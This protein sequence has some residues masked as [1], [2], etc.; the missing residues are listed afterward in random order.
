MTN[1]SQTLDAKLEAALEY[2]RLGWPVFPCRG[3]E[4]AT[5]HGCRD[6]TTDPAI[7]REWWEGKYRGCNVAIATG[8]K[9]WALDV[10][11]DDDGDA[12][13]FRLEQRYSPLPDTVRSITG[14]GGA[15]YLFKMNGTPIRNSV[16]KMAGIA[17]GLDTRGDGGYIIVPPSIHPDTKAPY[18]WEADFGPADFEPVEAPAWLEAL[19][20]RPERPERIVHEG[21]RREK[22]EGPANSY[23]QKALDDECHAIE[24]APPGA[25]EST[26]NAAALKIGGLVAGGELDEDYAFSALLKAGM[27]MPN[28]DSRKPWKP[29]QIETKLMRAMADGGRTPRKAPEPRGRKRQADSSANAE[30][31]TRTDERKADHGNARNGQA[32]GSTP[33]QANEDAIAL[34]FATRHADTLRYCH[35]WGM[36]L[37]WDGARWRRERRRLAFHFAREV[38]REANWEGKIGPAKASTAAGVERFAQADPRLATISDEWDVDPWKLGTPGGTVN[39]RTGAL[40][41]ARQLDHITKLTAVAPADPLHSD[42]CPLW[43]DFLHQATKGD[44]DLIRF[45]QQMAGYC[46]TGDVS[47][48]CLFFV[49]GPGGNGKGV[50]LQTIGN[51]LGEYGASAGMDTFTASHGDKHP[52]DLA[53]LKGARM[54]TASE[55]EEGRAWAEARIKE[56]TGNERPISARFMRQDFFE[57]MPTFKLVFVGNHKPVLRNV[58]DAARR[59]FNIIPFVHQPENPDKGLKD[60]LRAEYPAILQWMIDGCLDWQRNGLIRPSSVGK[61]TDEYFKS[62]DLFGQWLEECCE[63]HPGNDMRLETAADLFASW[64]AFA[65]SN[66]EHPGNGKALGDKLTQRDVG[67]VQKRHPMNGKNCKMRTGISLIRPA[68]NYGDQD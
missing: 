51:I 64:K 44:K 53:K 22:R 63:L 3:K 36:W 21:R 59:R 68:P 40:T 60:K 50:F 62:Q 18:Q 30:Q 4:P 2:A 29:R 42:G 7:I 39:L 9:V 1:A 35:D 41:P 56:L 5:E 65:E 48:E 26:L 43:L 6:A 19:A 15:H 11:P 13:L 58:D 34:E 47:E 24:D 17:P 8:G 23:G 20:K 55:T 54:V 27:A 33:P 66:G 67:S 37:H 31:Q 38:A 45:L 10:D 46:L 12:S 28:Y 16:G 32:D 52:T 25:Q 61:A 57:Y 49:Y 14:G